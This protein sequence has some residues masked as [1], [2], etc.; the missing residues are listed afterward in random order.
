MPFVRRNLA[1]PTLLMM[2]LIGACA[3]QQ[4]SDTKPH[5]G[6]IWVQTAAEYAALSKQAYNAATAALDHAIADTKWS[7]LPDQA[8]AEMLPVAIIF[9][10]DETL[11]SNADFQAEFEPPFSNQKLDD[12]NNANIAV[13]VPGAAEFAG[14]ARS[15]GATLFFVTN[16]PCEILDGVDDPCPQEKT[17]IQ[18]LVE[19]GIPADSEHVMHAYE[20][21][22]WGKEKVVRRMLIAESHRVIFLVGDDL[23]DFISCSRLKPANPCVSGATRASRSAAV[24]QYQEYWGERWF[25]LPNPMHGSWTTVR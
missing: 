12:W 6:I 19:S 4:L 18:D 2:L 13:G 21:P 8:N 16:R 5:P 14:A 15:A 9:D 22:E 17:T 10:V 7:A 25:V 3:Q 23:G 11:V 1:F 24:E 20:Q